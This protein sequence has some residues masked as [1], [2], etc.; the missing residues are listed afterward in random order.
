M[1]DK[2]RELFSS[3]LKNNTEATSQNFASIMKDKLNDALEIRKV[4]L[5]SKIF[6]KVEVQES[7]ELEE[8]MTANAASKVTAAQIEK[9]ID[10]QNFKAIEQLTKFLSADEYELWSKNGFE[11]RTYE[12]LMKQRAKNMKEA[13]EKIACLKCDAVS[14]ATVWK[15]NKGFC[16]VCKVSTQ[17]VAES[18]E[19]EEATDADLK[20]VIDTAKKM[21]GKISGNTA[22]FG[23]DSEITFSIE[24]GKIKFDGGKLGG[25][26]YFNNVNDAIASLTIGLED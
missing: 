23:K 20:K 6:N 19:L 11:G 9:Y 5:T 18:V 10:S 8:G 7:V 12:L 13:V 25:V 22:N 2:I 14:T 21:G 4:G 1:N 15:K 24:K 16:P 26:E 17:G 3:L